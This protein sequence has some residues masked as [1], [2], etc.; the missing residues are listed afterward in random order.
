MADVAQELS[1]V[2]VVLA[3]AHSMTWVDWVILAAHAVAAGA[4]T[5]AVSHDIP[6]AVGA[7]LAAAGVAAGNHF[8]TAPADR[9][10]PPKATVTPLHAGETRETL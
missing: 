8:R 4:A 9:S 7:A 10:A 3:N 2:G 5:Y 1:A 6:A